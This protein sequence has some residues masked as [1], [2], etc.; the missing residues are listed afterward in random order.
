GNEQQRDPNGNGGDNEQQRDPNGNGGGNEQRR[1]PPQNEGTIYE[2]SV[3]PV[4]GPQGNSEEPFNE[5]S[6]DGED[7]GGYSGES[8]NLNYEGDWDDLEELI[9]GDGEAANSG[10]NDDAQMADDELSD[11]GSSND[12]GAINEDSENEDTLTELRSDEEW[13]TTSDDRRGSSPD[14][15][16]PDNPSGSRP[17]EISDEDRARIHELL[18]TINMQNFS[19]AW[20]VEDILGIPEGLIDG[21]SVSPG[22]EKGGAIPSNQFTEH[23]PPGGDMT[24]PPVTEHT[25]PGGDMTQPPEYSLDD[26]LD[27]PPPY[28]LLDDPLSEINPP[29]YSPE[30]LPPPAYSLLGEAPL[31]DLLSELDTWLGDSSNY[32]GPS[33]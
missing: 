23:T 7:I 3:D 9:F 33:N 29:A 1:D 6:V 27:Q 20:S 5:M 8:F 16:S 22:E 31:S 24:Q 26:P 25:P 12:E 2:M 30:T 17:P 19:G 21:P 13:E 10:S 4:V 11:T 28:S 15:M 14:E 32:R 18:G